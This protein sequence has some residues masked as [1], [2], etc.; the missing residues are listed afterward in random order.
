MPTWTETELDDLPKDLLRQLSTKVIGPYAVRVRGQRNSYK[1][2]YESQLMRAN[3]LEQ[4]LRKAREACKRM[5][6]KL[7]A[8]AEV[9]GRPPHGTETE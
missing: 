1:S 8:N 3:R 9:T 4:E 7:S 6:E 5:A 2:H